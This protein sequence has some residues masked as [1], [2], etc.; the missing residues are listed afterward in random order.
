MSLDI[1]YLSQLFDLHEQVVVLTGGLGQ[2][3]TN[4]TEALLRANARVAIFD[5]VDTPNEQ[6]AELAKNFPLLFLKVDVT[7]EED[8]LR[9]IQQ[10]K[11]IWDI[12]TILINNAGWRASPTEPSKASV[13]FEEYPM[14]VWE[15]VF[16]TNTMSAAICSKLVGNE[17]IKAGRAGTIVNIASHYALVSPDQRSY[18]HREAQ[19]GKKFVKDASYSASKAALL[20]LTRDLA[21]Q[22]APHNIRVMSL[23]PGGV[24]TADVDKDFM[25]QY[26]SRT[27]LARMANAN[28]YN[29]AIL[30]LLTDTYSTG[31]NLIVDGGYTAW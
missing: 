8:V 2:L 25:K 22:W 23:C 18:A 9:A 14:N 31:S 15:D 11:T 21:T 27:P 24:I 5:V 20:A 12:P 1:S 28:E 4:Y 6:L 13:P 29:R 26:S 10:V 19:T 17:L 30:F 3:G 7:N 16:R